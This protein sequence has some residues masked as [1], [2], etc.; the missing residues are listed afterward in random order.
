MF[1]L[2]IEGIP[3]SGGSKTALPLTKKGGAF[4][5]TGGYPQIQKGSKPGTWWISGCRPLI[6]VVD[7]ADLGKKKNRRKKWMELISMMARTQFRQERYEGAI[8]LTMDFYMPRPKC[9]YRTGKYSHL[10]KDSAPKEHIVKP[11]EDKLLRPAQDALSGICWKDDCQIIS[12]A[13]TKQY[14][15]RGKE[16][17]DIYISTPEE[18]SCSNSTGATQCKDHG[19]QL[20]QVS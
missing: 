1:K 19:K 12:V 6:N 17:V 18:L 14:T 5:C 15:E 16:G 13:V 2:Q 11:D 7:T 10:L 3:V 9:H 4:Y 20:Q 8:I